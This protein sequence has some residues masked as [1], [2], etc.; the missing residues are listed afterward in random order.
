MGVQSKMI[1]YRGMG[2]E[3]AVGY[4]ATVLLWSLENGTDIVRFPSII[5][6]LTVRGF[7]MCGTTHQRGLFSRQI[8][9]PSIC[10]RGVETADM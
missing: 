3:V 9:T 10:H 7:G 2:K 6:K 1:R 5:V 8:T 4:V